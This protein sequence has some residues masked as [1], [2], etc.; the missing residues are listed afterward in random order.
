MVMNFGETGGGLR[1]FLDLEALGSFTHDQISMKGTEPIEL[2]LVLESQRQNMGIQ[3]LILGIN[4][5]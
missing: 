3:Q 5:R 1:Q 4:R 2:L